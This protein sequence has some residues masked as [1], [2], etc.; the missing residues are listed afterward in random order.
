MLLL[1]QA[2]TVA[3]PRTNELI[4]GLLSLALLVGRLLVVA[5]VVWQ[6]VLTRRAAERTADAAE[7]R[8]L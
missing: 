2:P 6:V 8:N 3:L 4:F 1:A 5:F 7:R